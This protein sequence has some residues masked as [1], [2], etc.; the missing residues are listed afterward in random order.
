MKSKT[1]EAKG[2]ALVGDRADLALRPLG[3]KVKRSEE[4]APA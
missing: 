3:D 2:L 1:H 4:E